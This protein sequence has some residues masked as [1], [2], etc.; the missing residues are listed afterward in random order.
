MKETFVYPNVTT[1]RKN[2]IRGYGIAKMQGRKLEDNR[3]NLTKLYNINAF[4]YCSD[5]ELINNPDIRFALLVLDIA[6]FKSINEFCTR[7]VG[8]AVLLHIA[9]VLREYQ[10]EHVVLAQFRADYFA[11]LTPFETR[12]EL[13]DLCIEICNKIDAFPINHKILPAIG[14]CATDDHEMPCSLLRDYAKMACDSIKG[15]FYSKYA[16]FDSKM[17]D[18]MMNEKQIENNIVDAIKQGHLKAF[19][20]PKVNMAT[21]EI[22]GG[23]ALCRWINPDTGIIPPGIFIPVLEKNGLIIDVDMIIW[24]QIFAFQSQRLKDRKKVVP[25]SI[26]ISR[27]HAYD[28]SFRDYLVML[29]NKYN[30]P[31][32]LIPLELTESTFSDRADCMYDNMQFL[33][34]QGFMFSMDDFGTGYSTLTM[35]N[36]Q[37]VDEIKIDRGFVENL[38]NDNGQKLLYGLVALL[39]S[40]NKKIIVEGIETKEQME[41]MLENG[42]SSAQGFYFYKPMSI[43]DFEEMLN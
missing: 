12:D 20:Q 2:E 4:L 22:I 36:E 37:P 31:P 43:S 14:I 26:N 10:K 40:L 39:K 29:S 15:K 17:L 27:L 24:E 38:N 21:G 7:Q 9:D 30:V 3:S 6:N 28:S 18:D 13:A 16:F 19:I 33:K 41:L 34:S 32:E 42:V 1:E 5:Q 11:M 25:I 8:D 35:L 23:E